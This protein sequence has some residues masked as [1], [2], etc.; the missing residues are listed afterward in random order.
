MKNKLYLTLLCFFIVFSITCVN[1]SE[2]N[3]TVLS[4]KI[5]VDGS[6]S[7]QMTNP[8]IQNAIDSAKDGDT[9][10]ITG[11]NYEHCHFIIDKNLT[12]I[13]NVGTSME[14][15]PSNIKGS[16]GIGIFYFN[17]KAS[18]SI[19]SGFTFINDNNKLGTV[20]PYAIYINGANDIQIKNCSINKVS[21]GPGIYVKETSNTI[22]DNVLIQKSNNGIQ[23]ED[24]THTTIKNSNI[25]SNEN[26]GIL[27]GKNNNYIN[28]IN[29]SI[30]EN[31]WKG[32]LL[33]SANKLNITSNLI[34]ANRD[35]A[36][37][38]RSNEGTGIYVNSS[39]DTLKIKGNA[40]IENGNYGVYNSYLTMSSLKNQYV[41]EIDENIF[42]FHLTRG[43]YTQQTVEGGTG[44]I[45]VESN[46]YS[47][48]QFCPSTY[49][50]E[51]LLRDGS[52]DLIFS[53]ITQLSKGIYTVSFIKKNTGEIATSLN[54][55]NVTFFLNK[56]GTKA[57][58][59]EN[60]T[61]QVTNIENGSATANFKNSTYKATN[62]NI[63]AISQGYG[64][65]TIESSVNRLCAVYFV[66][67]SDIPSNKTISTILKGENIE[68]YYG[69][70]I[71]Y[72]TTLLDENNNILPRKNITLIVNN[73]SYMRTTNDEGIA[74][75]RINFV[76][77]IYNIIA[78]FNGT[79]EYD[80]ASCKN[81]IRILSTITG[82]DIV[83]IFKNETQY[84]VT[85]LDKNGNYQ[86]DSKVTFNINGIMYTHSVI[87]GKAKMN[88]NLPQG[89]Y[90]ITAM[91][92]YTHQNHSN[93]II[94]LPSI[95]ENNNLTKYFRNE[96]TYSVRVVD[97]NG[98]PVSSGVD[99]N[100]NINGRIYKRTTNNEGYAKLNINLP[101]GNYIIT[102]EHNGCLVS[103]EITVL[104]ILITENMTKTY[105][106]STPFVVK[107]MDGHGNKYPSQ[108]IRMNIN[109][110][111]YQRT[112]D[113]EGIA[114]L[115]INLPC[116]EYIITSS[117]NESNV[118]N[119]ITVV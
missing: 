95:I 27:I 107:L 10:E 81:S 103:N 57:S 119:K 21:D 69:N 20:N 30:T 71:Y 92:T 87:E 18:G 114:R 93:K 73:N 111:F 8:T 12:I 99:V 31:N 67:D 29:N 80:M 35:N 24:S 32:I 48:E 45:Y 37:Q 110:V 7:N 2:L 25:K 51:G 117:Y 72:T 28:I 1:A 66:S 75:M 4:E 11:T 13:S 53:N 102:A 108:M 74:S 14:T 64:P 43:I 105:G 33:Q 39:I 115:N 68:M 59:E 3:D 94:V 84:Y 19:L 41:E 55:G 96:S 52:R 47:N 70:E 98:N 116:G 6:S 65:I 89:E 50:E 63:T 109:G 86:N 112:T 54:K 91:N 38:S 26:T 60:D 5:I 34:T 22:I 82:E 106:S 62:N 23:I 78:I 90:I 79:E 42:I 46:F 77:G 16:D 40:I 97:A 76:P 61:Y 88:I 100:F 113:E 118:A 104:P 36:V 83:K 9:I 56:N 85:V 49:Y 101:E 44:P 58:I 17:E 15:C